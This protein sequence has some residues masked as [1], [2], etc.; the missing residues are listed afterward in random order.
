[1]SAPVVL[2]NGGVLFLSGDA[3]GGSLTAAD[4]SGFTA[5]A[6]TNLTDWV[7][8]SNA[9]SITNGLLMLQDSGQTNFP[10]RFYRIL[11]Q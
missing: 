6:S 2:A 4:L 9:L 5:L 3:D 10:A 7:V 1:M 8:L 11:E